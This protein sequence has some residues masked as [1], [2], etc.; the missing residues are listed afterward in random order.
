MTDNQ[1]NRVSVTLQIQG[2]QSHIN[3]AFGTTFAQQLRFAFP[4]SQVRIRHS[5]HI[6]EFVTCD[7]L[8]F[9]ALRYDELDIHVVVGDNPTLENSLI[10]PSRKTQAIYQTPAELLFQAIQKEAEQ[11][12]FDINQNS[13][14]WLQHVPEYLKTAVSS[15]LTQKRETPLLQWTP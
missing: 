13:D 10:L 3:H 11:K 12:A 14:N 15:Y 5:H 2:T 4:L 1:N 8:N 6:G 7:L 9:E